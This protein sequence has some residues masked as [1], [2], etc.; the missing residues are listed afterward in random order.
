MWEIRAFLVYA[1]QTFSHLNIDMEEEKYF[2]LFSA[3]LCDQ[4]WWVRNELV[5][6]YESVE[7]LRLAGWIYKLELF[8]S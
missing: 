6:S 8:H 1:G 4:I 5:F 3:I 7:T 2:V